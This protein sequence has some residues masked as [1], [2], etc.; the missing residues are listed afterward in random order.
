M[1]VTSVKIVRPWPVDEQCPTKR[2]TG[3][4]R[5]LVDLEWS[6]YGNNKYMFNSLFC[7]E[8]KIGILA[9]GTP[10]GDSR[11]PTCRLKGTHVVAQGSPRGGTREPMWWL[12]GPHVVAQGSRRGGSRDPT[13]WLKRAHVVAQGSPRGGSKDPTWW[14]KGPYK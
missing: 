2:T 14:L 10:H 12:K 9:K 7:F 1:P 5:F 8:C 3:I 11:D 6:I 13:W 4:K